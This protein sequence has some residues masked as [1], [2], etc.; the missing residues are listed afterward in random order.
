MYLAAADG[1]HAG[2]ALRFNPKTEGAPPR[3]CRF[4]GSGF[5][6]TVAFQV[7]PSGEKSGRLSSWARAS[8]H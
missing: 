7:L 8:R 6:A 1:L 5:K 3:V 4:D 2:F